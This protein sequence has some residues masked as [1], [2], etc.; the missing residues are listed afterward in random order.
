MVWRADPVDFSKRVDRDAIKGRSVLITGGADGLGHGIAKAVA[1]SGAYVTI[2][3]MNETLGQQRRSE[4]TEAG[5]HVHSV[6]ADITSWE[7]LT[8][9]FKAAIEYSPTHSLDIVIANAGLSGG[10]ILEKAFPKDLDENADLPQPSTLD[11]NVNLTGTY[12]TTVLALHYF[13]KTHSPSDNFKKHLILMSSLAGYAEDTLASTYMAAKFGVRGLWKSIRYQEDAFGFPFRTQLIAPCFVRTKMTESF[14]DH[15]AKAGVNVSQVE[16]V[17][18]PVM[19]VLCDEKVSGRSLC[20]V[21][22][23]VFD[24]GDDPAGGDGSK[25]LWKALADEEYFGPGAKGLV[26]Y[27]EFFRSE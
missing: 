23:K 26:R 15:I 4:L 5:Y 13:K 12:Y 6:K 18:G 24:M 3:D 21:G 27:D 8:L 25:A 17:V 20:T 16:D 10:S 1:A 14:V 7:S 2:A 22:N 11:L 9:A 19:R